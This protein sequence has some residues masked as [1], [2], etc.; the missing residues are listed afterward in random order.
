MLIVF[1]ALVVVSSTGLGVCLNGFSVFHPLPPSLPPPPLSLSLSLSLS[2]KGIRDYLIKN[3]F[4]C[5]SCK[6]LTSPDRLT[7]NA[8]VR[9]VS[10]DS[11]LLSSTGSR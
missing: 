11:N 10:C 6:E 3:N 7:A 1:V 2:L 9:L 8:S 5:P 4:V